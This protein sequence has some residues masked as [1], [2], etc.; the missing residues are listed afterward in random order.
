MSFWLLFRLLLLFFLGLFRLVLL[1]RLHFFITI[2]EFLEFLVLLARCNLPAVLI[3]VGHQLKPVVRHHP[4]KS[5]INLHLLNLFGHPSKPRI[6]RD[7]LEPFISLRLDLFSRLWV[8]W[9][10]LLSSLLL[11]LKQLQLSLSVHVL[12]PIIIDQY[13]EGT[14]NH[15]R[16]TI[17][18]CTVTYC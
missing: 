16:R 6:I 15:S 7:T 12:T 9:S 8:L 3:N 11:Q 14:N 1:L 18:S 17:F 2:V 4:V 13:G 10:M 5:L